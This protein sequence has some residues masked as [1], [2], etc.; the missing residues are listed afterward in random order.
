MN[1]DSTVFQSI[2]TILSGYVDGA[3][4]IAPHTRIIADLEI[5]SVNVFDL[6]MEIEDANDVSI[7]METISTI[8]TVGELTDVVESLIRAK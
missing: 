4:E 5:D 8:H 1:V 6:I 2:R 3:H 7:S